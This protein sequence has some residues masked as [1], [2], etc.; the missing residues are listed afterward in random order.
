[1]MRS[2]RLSGFIAVALLTFVPYI[3]AAEHP[4]GG[5]EHPGEETSEHPGKE[6]HKVT[7]EILSKAIQDYIKNESKLKGGFFLM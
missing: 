7:K 3:W 4:G 6:E 1:M 5:K 2:K